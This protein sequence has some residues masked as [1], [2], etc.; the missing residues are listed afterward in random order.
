M[1]VLALAR[2]LPDVAAFAGGTLDMLVARGDSMFLAEV[3]VESDG[4]RAERDQ[5]GTALAGAVGAEWLGTLPANG[6]EDGRGLRDPVMDVLRRARPDAILVSAPDPGEQMPL[7]EVVFNAAYCSTI[8]N[9]VSSAGLE[10]ASVRAQIVTLDHRSDHSPLPDTYVDISDR[11]ERKSEL[12]ELC[13]PLWGAGDVD[14][15]AEIVSRAR[16]V[17]VQVEFAE[18]FGIERAWGRLRA[19]RWL[20]SGRDGI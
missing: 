1:R 9:Y 17:Q 19:Q 8:P 14:E 16:G 11:W 12:V 18:A 6:G 4:D 20:P 15:V 13:R 7:A 5:V 10:A 3:P 2:E